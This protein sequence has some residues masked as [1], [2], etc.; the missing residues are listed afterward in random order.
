MKLHAIFAVITALGT[1][2]LAQDPGFKLPGSEERKTPNSADVNSSGTAGAGQINNMELLDNAMPLQ[3]G[4]KLSFRIVEERLPAES[5]RVMDAGSIVAKHVGPVTAVGKTC[6]DLAYQVKSLLE[7][8]VFVKATV[9]IVLD[10]RIR[11]QGGGNGLRI[12]ESETFTVFGQVLR[13][14]K[15]ELPM[16]E[17]V[18]ISQAVLRAGGPAQFARLKAVKILRALPTGGTKTILVDLES[19]MVK[20]RL[21]RDVFVRGGDVIIVMEKNVNF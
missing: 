13:Q 6:R 21:E 20:G 9:I 10:E 5:I 3:I 17:D 1:Q 19:I 18:S 4:D 2:V 7:K 14:G 8:S 16:D 15:Y 11:F 12:G